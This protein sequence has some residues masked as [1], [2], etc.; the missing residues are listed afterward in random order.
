MV[1][2]VGR[3]EQLHRLLVFVAVVS[4]YTEDKVVAGDPDTSCLIIFIQYLELRRDNNFSYLIHFE[5]F[6]M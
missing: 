5:M 1:D 6:Q 2:D 4:I 3:G